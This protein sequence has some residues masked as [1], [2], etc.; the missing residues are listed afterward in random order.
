MPRET[1]L[2]DG[3]EISQ[4]PLEAQYAMEMLL[5]MVRAQ[6]KIHEG[7]YDDC[8]PDSTYNLFITAYDD[9]E[10]AEGAQLRAMQNMVNRDCNPR[11]R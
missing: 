3:V 5:P 10:I 6:K 11:T 4:I 8:N 7:N 2:I 9:P 1:K